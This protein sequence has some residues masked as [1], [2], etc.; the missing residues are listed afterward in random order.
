MQRAAEWAALDHSNAQV[1]YPTWADKYFSV[2]TGEAVAVPATVPMPGA[3][4]SLGSNGYFT[5]LG[6]D[7]GN[8]EVD[9]FALLMSQ[10]N[11]FGVN[12]VMKRSS[13]MSHGIATGRSLLQ[14]VNPPEICNTGV[15][16]VN[17][18]MGG[19]CD[20]A[21]STK[22]FKVSAVYHGPIACM[23]LLFCQLQKQ[24]HMS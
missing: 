10:R 15:Q 7:A 14:Q 20:L 3:L 2:L 24:M 4:K 6:S 1:M 19:S 18:P 5:G 11:D 8:D 16:T 17:I 13:N 23:Q 12:P 22:Y 21:I 9:P